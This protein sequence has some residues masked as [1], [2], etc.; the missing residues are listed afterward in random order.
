MLA[1]TNCTFVV[2]GV[3]VAE[4]QEAALLA[5]DMGKSW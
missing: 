2:V 3:W 5:K 1:T 4:P